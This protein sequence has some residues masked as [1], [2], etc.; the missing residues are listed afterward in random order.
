MRD[1]K[2]VAKDFDRLVFEFNSPDPDSY[3][4][5]MWIDDS[6]INYYF[7]GFG[8]DSYV[9]KYNSGG[10]AR[11]AICAIPAVA[12]ASLVGIDKTNQNG[13]DFVK[14]CHK[15]YN[16]DNGEGVVLNNTT[17]SSANN[18]NYTVQPNLYFFQLADKFW[19][20]YNF[21]I[22]MKN[23]ADKFY[24]A[25]V[26]MGGTDTSLPDYNHSSFDFRNMVP[27]DNGLWT[28]PDAAGGF[29]WI[30]YSAYNSYDYDRFLQGAEW[31]I[32]WLQSLNYNPQTH[33]TLAF[34]ALTAAKMNAE[35]GYGYEVDKLLNWVFSVPE[36]GD[37]RPG[38]GIMA[39]EKWGG[40]DADGLVGHTGNDYAFAYETFQTAGT[41]APLP[42]YNASYA[43][44]IG[45][46][47]LNLAN[48][49]RLY[50]GNFLDADHQSCFNW[51]NNY[52]PNG[53][54]PYEALRG[55]W[56]GNS[57]YIMGDSS[58]NDWD[59]AYTDLCP[60][61]GASVG[62]LAAVVEKTNTPKILQLDLTATDFHNRGAYPTFLYYNPYTNSKNVQINL[63]TE[64]VDVYD[65]VNKEFVLRDANG[66]QT[67]TLSGDS[68]IVLVL[69]PVKGTVT[70]EKKNGLKQM[71]I[72][73]I[74]VDYHASETALRPLPF[75]NVCEVNTD[76][77][78]KWNKGLNADSHDVYLG[79]DYT[80][81]ANR[82]RSSSTFMGNQTYNSYNPSQLSLNTTYYW[83]VDEIAD[84]IV[85]PGQVWSFTTDSYWK[86]DLN[87][88]GSVN[89]SDLDFLQNYWLSSPPDGSEVFPDTDGDGF[90]DFVD[91][92]ALAEDWDK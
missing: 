19:R 60:Y 79:T 68:A 26:Q 39:G 25:S 75:N 27:V 73:N 44:D 15:L 92:S 88:D 32:E 11:E 45:K 65:T 22:I 35:K 8:L 52:D 72:D 38:W 59:R 30:C 1:W 40:Y 23:V 86:G 71:L 56:E 49:A 42:R 36:D 50:Y 77:T 76:V 48:S 14:M 64:K 55:I 81:L 33:V 4:P 62:M 67:F 20:E 70:F 16:I 10:N 34:G 89:I 29:A 18:F 61:G 9:G 41:L 46:W 83:A 80:Q 21:Y 24:N 78:L 51:V 47:M 69:T 17:A 2:Q 54:I 66:L 43:C 37:A 63:G 85:H 13:Y 31:G 28:K 7:D 82:T 84:G 5:I 57:P 87:R 6:N 91:F 12:G 74:V 90:I 53:A 3:T 58:K